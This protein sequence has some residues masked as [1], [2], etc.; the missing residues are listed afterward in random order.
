MSKP[1]SPARS[2]KAGPSASK[3]ALFP[4][5][6][7]SVAVTPMVKRPRYF[8]STKQLIVILR[9]LQESSVRQRRSESGSED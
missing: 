8:A 6:P 5:L 9:Y 7:G 4:P 3:G 1:A 2:A